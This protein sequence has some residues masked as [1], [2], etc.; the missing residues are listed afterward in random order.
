M[1][2]QRDLI[3]NKP[4]QPYYPQTFLIF[5]SRKAMAYAALVKQSTKPVDNSVGKV[6][7]SAV[8]RHNTGLC[9]KLMDFSPNLKTL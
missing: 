4:Q 7:A 1:L 5:N 9:Y 8:S 2:P 3:K 6:R